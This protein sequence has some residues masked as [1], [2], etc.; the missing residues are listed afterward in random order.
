MNAKL[1]ATFPAMFQ[2][3]DDVKGSVDL[4]SFRERFAGKDKDLA[5]AFDGMCSRLVK[6]VFEEATL[7]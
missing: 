7:R 3:L 6:V 1:S 4:S 2:T 5:Q